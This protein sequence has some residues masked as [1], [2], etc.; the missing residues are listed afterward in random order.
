MG[1]IA[2]GGVRVLNDDVVAAT[3]VTAEEIDAVTERE[4][5]ELSRREQLYRGDRAPVDVTGRVA[6]LVDDGLATG[7]TMRA[8]VAALKER[9]AGRIVVAVPAAAPQ[10]CALLEREADEVVAT[11]KPDPFRA[12]GLWYINF[13]PTTDEEVRELLERASAG[14]AQA[15]SG[16]RTDDADRGV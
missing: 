2:S 9:N 11:M 13:S 5:E 12:V 7:A 16:E 4:K 6:I 1:A 3:G 8:G 10:S 15:A 14:P